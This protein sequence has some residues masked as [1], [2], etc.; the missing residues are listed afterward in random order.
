MFSK[1]IRESAAGF[2]NV[3]SFASFAGDNID[4][5]AGGACEVLCDVEMTLGAS[6]AR[7]STGNVRTRIAP[8]AIT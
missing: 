4:Y 7:N 3:K 1:T 5:I 6:D 2:A 8:R